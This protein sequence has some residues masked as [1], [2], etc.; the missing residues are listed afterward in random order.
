MNVFFVLVEEIIGEEDGGADLLG[1]FSEQEALE[2]AEL[3]W[4]DLMDNNSGFEVEDNDPICK[5]AS[6]GDDYVSVRV[7]GLSDPANESTEFGI[8]RK[9]KFAKPAGFSVGGGVAGH[10]T[11]VIDVTEG[12][13]NA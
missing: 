12:E 2:E 1:P 8:C 3:Q 10:P 13:Q 11:V 6:Q 9:A 7:F 4:C 5:M